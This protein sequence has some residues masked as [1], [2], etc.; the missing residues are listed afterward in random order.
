MVIINFMWLL[1]FRKKRRSTFCRLQQLISLNIFY[2]KQEWN[3]EN[4]V[5]DDEAKFVNII[6][7]LCE[8]WCIRRSLNDMKIN[9]FCASLTSP[10]MLYL[11][12]AKFISYVCQEV[13]ALNSISKLAIPHSLSVLGVKF[14]LKSRFVAFASN[15]MPVLPSSEPYSISLRT[16]ANP[17]LFSAFHRL[18]SLLRDHPPIFQTFG[19]GHYRLWLDSSFSE[20]HFDIL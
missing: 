14:I 19:T 3:V 9:L 11:K 6:E 1:Y 4:F 8:R 18:L 20:D 10:I 12:S 17:P 16:E 2:R 13:D 5:R 15:L 7:F